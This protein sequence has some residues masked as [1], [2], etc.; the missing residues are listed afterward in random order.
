MSPAEGA[1]QVEIEVRNIVQGINAR[2]ISRGVRGVN[3][4]RNAANVVLGQNGSGRV[5]RNGHVAS[6]PGQPPAPDTGNLRRNW[7]QRVYAHGNGKGNGVTV[8]LQISSQMF[9]Q[10][11]LEN[12]TRKM[13]ARPFHE[14]IKTKARPEI[15]ALFASI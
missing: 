12:G 8:H 6:A 7:R 11:F 13:A 5:Y 14:P 15:V 9:Y 1:R 3:L 4:L 2:A 10:Q